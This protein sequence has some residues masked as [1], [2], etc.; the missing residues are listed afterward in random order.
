MDKILLLLT[1]LK[2]VSLKDLSDLP[3]ENQYNVALRLEQLQEELNQALEYRA[4][5][6]Q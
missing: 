4:K 5:S 2:A 6:L 3:D 1:D